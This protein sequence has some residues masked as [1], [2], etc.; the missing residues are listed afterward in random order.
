MAPACLVGRPQRISRITERRFSLEHGPWTMF[1][2]KIDYFRSG[3]FHFTIVPSSNP[4]LF[5]SQEYSMI[6]SF[7]GLRFQVRTFVQSRVYA[8]GSWT[9]TVCRIVRESSR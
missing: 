8:F 1:H 2:L 5:S 3:Y 4:R 9:V 7:A 6:T